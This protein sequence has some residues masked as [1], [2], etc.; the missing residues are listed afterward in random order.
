MKKALLALFVASFALSAQAGMTGEQVYTKHCAMCH[1]TGA[2]GAP[3]KGD[4]KAWAPRARQGMATLVKNAKSGIR[5]MPPKGTC[6]TCTD[7]ELEGAV[8]FISGAK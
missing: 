1:A 8:K 6:M 5:A 7:A 4:A 2:A 3:K